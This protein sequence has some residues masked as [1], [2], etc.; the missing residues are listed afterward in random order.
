MKLLKKISLIA[1]IAFVLSGCNIY[2]QMVIPTPYYP[3]ETQNQNLGQ[4]VSTN[5]TTINEK[6]QN[7]NQSV[8]TTIKES[9]IKTK[10]KTMVQRIPFPEAEYASLAKTGSATVT[11]YIYALTPTGKKVYAR[12]TRL[13]LNPVT[14]YSTQWYNESYLGGAKM[15]KVDPRLFNYLKFTTSDNNGKFEFLNVPSGSYYLIGVI[16]CGSECGYSQTKNIRVT[17]KI[18]VVGSEIK[19]IDLSKSI[20]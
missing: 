1:T 18:S 7:L 6:K 14:S 8:T 5:D 9:P 16:K 11:G 20:Q 4:E 12:Q 3:K 13:Y 19:S 15:S 10:N 2:R 17:K